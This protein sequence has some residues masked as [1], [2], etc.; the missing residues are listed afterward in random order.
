MCEGLGFDDIG[1]SYLHFFD[2]QE[3]N[4]QEYR[5]IMD[6]MESEL[7]AFKLGDSGT[8]MKVTDFGRRVFQ[9]GGYLAF[10]VQKNIESKEKEEEQMLNTRIALQQLRLN[11]WYLKSRWWPHLI[12][13]IALILSIIAIFAK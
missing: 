12:S 1:D 4:N 9:A 8:R 11:D 3:G 6:R 7:L 13:A 5:I 10:V 2:P